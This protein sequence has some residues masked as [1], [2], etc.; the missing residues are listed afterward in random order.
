MLD[1]SGLF[2]NF[3]VFENDLAHIQVGQQIT[4][5]TNANPN[6]NIKLK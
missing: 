4:V 5:N 3:K 2:A 6:K 1:P